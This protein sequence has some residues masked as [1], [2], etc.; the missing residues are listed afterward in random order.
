MSIKIN[1]E[2]NGMINNI[3]VL[4]AEIVE[5]HK[6]FE[7]MEVVCPYCHRRHQHGWPKS[8]PKSQITHRAS[9]C[10]VEE[11]TDESSKGYYIKLQ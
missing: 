5:E 6:D 2:E 9:H 4:L 11:I 3:P 8:I 10:K 7:L 1:S